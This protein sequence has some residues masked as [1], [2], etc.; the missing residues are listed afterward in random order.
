MS[1]FS[2]SYIGSGLLLPPQMIPLKEKTDDWKKDTMDALESIAISQRNSNLRLIENY[3]MI[4][5]K[6]IFAHYFGEEGYDSM[7][8]Q[9]SKEFSIPNYLK[10]YDIIS[11]VINT[12]TG[13]WLKRPDTFRVKDW[14]EHGTN[15][16][17][18]T[19]KEL[20]A[21]YVEETI[22]A[23][24]NQRLLS[25]GLLDVEPQS[26][27]EAD[28]IQQQIE[29]V[30]KSMTPP[31]IESYM[32]TDFRTA[33]EKWG[34][35]R[36]KADKQRFAL[37]EKE[38]VE[39]EDMLVA[40]RCFRHFYLTSNGYS[41]ET[42]NPINTFYHKSR[43]I[44]YI[45]EGN[46]VGRIF[47]LTLSD[48]IDRYGH[49]MTPEQ[50]DNIKGE[51]KKGQTK[52]N[53]AP[54]TSYVYNDYAVPFQGYYGYDIVR[55]TNDPFRL[56]NEQL[57]YIDTATLNNMSRNGG[58]TTFNGYYTVIEAYW[59][60]QE[61]IG[62]LTYFDEETGEIVKKLVDENYIVPDYIVE[63]KTLFSDEQDINTITYTYINRV[64]KGVKINLGDRKKDIYIDVKP[65]EF[66]FKGDI[67]IY[68]AKLPVCG[69]IF[70]VRNS[71]SMS[72]VDLMKP[73]QIGYNVAMNQLYQLAEK[74]VGAFMVFDVNM[75]PN[76]KD[77]G[78]EDAW[79]KWMLIAKSLGMMPIDSS[80]QN[81]NGVAAA[82][83]GAF[84]RIFNMELSA[85]MAS[86]MTIAKFFE[87]QAMK[88]VGFN[89]Y[90][91]GQ[92]AS[93]STAEGVRV[94]TEQS[95]AQTESYFTN[96]SNYLRRCYRMN[97]DIAQYVG[98]KNED[99]S[100]SYVNSDLSN[101]V[102]KSLGTELLL[103]DLYV[104]V[105]NTQEQLR[106]LEALRQLGLQNNTTGATIA[107]LA[108]IVTTSSP[109]NIIRIL[110]E[111]VEKQEAL[112]QQNIEM[113]QKKLQQEADIAKYE[114]EKEDERNDKKI[115]GNIQIA[116]IGAESKLFQN[117]NY[118]PS[119]DDINNIQNDLQQQS[120]DIEREKLEHQKQTDNQKVLND[121]DLQIGKLALENKK[122]DASIQKQKDDI[123]YA[124]I[125]KGK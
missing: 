55:S 47:T 72:L 69:Q 85:Q 119:E 60:S 59:K 24:I 71:A 75:F 39:F 68:E 58:V 57:P 109:Q 73:H 80:P 22:N 33:I 56:E 42:W 110:K 82:A 104:F 113:E 19:K 107:D 32:K 93:T 35:A 13:E 120:I 96:F 117:R 108:E 89:E 14:S 79:E 4:K 2:S 43:E 92:Q 105:S 91:V 88:Q 27:E 1:I 23:E 115:N 65:L 18:R 8:S 36:L 21:E 20:I 50:M 121:R 53:E 51:Y 125:I 37:D 98:S 44:Q 34:E 16:F 28:Q 70:S 103:S 116:L 81:S 97:L 46:Y 52:W 9:L 74:E 95:Y 78:G 90:R 101:A 54:G 17:L 112:Q 99:V 5:G 84:P 102:A 12:L 86:R 63:S 38:K 62:L 45:E 114:Q 6:F 67:N 61:K 25:M 118:T 15:T 29:Q 83:G 122:I 77:W 40:D 7:I 26:Q 41:Q 64:W 3:E 123:T 11:P 106:Q 48:I 124:K 66:Q 111:S 76:S 10:H 100:F 31:E 30:K 87:E 94:G 49:R